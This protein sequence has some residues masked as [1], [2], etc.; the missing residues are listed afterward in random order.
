MND[1]I[2][3]SSLISCKQYVY[4]RDGQTHVMLIL[5]GKMLRIVDSIATLIRSLGKMKHYY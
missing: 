5:L 2:E 4:R 3:T 1:R